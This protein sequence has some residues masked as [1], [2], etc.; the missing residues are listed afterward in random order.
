MVLPLKTKSAKW[1]W[2]RWGPRPSI[3][4][5]LSTMSKILESLP[6]TIAAGVVLTVVMAFLTDSMTSAPSMSD[7]MKDAKEQMGDMVE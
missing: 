1:G 7:A 3:R 5:G 4:V 6:L 2:R